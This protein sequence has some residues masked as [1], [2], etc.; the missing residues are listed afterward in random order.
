MTDAYVIVSGTP[1]DAEDAEIPGVY[2]VQ[3]KEEAP[4]DLVE[5]T[6]LEAFHQN[7][8]IATLDD[9]DIRVVDAQGNPF[10]DQAGDASTRDT[11]PLESWGEFGGSLNPGDVPFAMPDLGGGPRP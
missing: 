2:L 11:Q 1:S 5:E 4:A 3:V 10:P 6:A 7:I 8:G 9:F